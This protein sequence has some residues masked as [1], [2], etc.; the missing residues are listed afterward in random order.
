MWCNVRFSLHFCVV[1]AVKTDTKLTLYH[2][3]KNFIIQLTKIKFH[4]WRVTFFKNFLPL[5]TFGMNFR[6]LCNR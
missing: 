4:I 6:F 1:N 5:K 2:M 3:G